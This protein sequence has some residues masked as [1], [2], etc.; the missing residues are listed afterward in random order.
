MEIKP[1]RAYRFDPAVVGNPGDCIVPPYDLSKPDVQEH[2]YRKNEYNVV[3]IIS[4]RISENDDEA[5]NQYTRAARHLKSWIEKGALKQDSEDSIYAYIQDFE[6]DGQKFHRSSFISLGRLEKYGEGVKAHEDT[7]DGVTA[8]F[9][10]LQRATEAKCGLIFMLYEDSKKIADKIIEKA[11]G[12]K[13]L[14]DCV[15]EDNVRHRLFKITDSKQIEIIS[16]MMKD[17]SCII[18]DGHHRYQT[19]LNYYNETGNPRAAWQLMAFANSLNEG[20]IV[21][22]THRLVVKL[23]NFDAKTLLAGL[24]ENFKITEYLFDSAETKRAAME[25]MLKQMK[26]ESDRDKNAY[27]IYLADGTFRTAVLKNKKAMDEA[28]AGKSKAWQKLEVSVLHKLILE[29]LLGIGEKELASKRHLEYIRDGGHSIEQI[30]ARVDSGQ[31]QAAFFVNP[32]KVKMIQEVANAGET[33]PQKST[34][35]YPKVFS[36][37]TI[38]KM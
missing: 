17:K 22:A 34:F 2:F 6:I 24:Q 21:L 32:E 25:K 36:G 15:D 29:K 35:F 18:A 16:R 27:G 20:V 19:A 3:R 14:I 23:K 28:A 38:Y 11:A 26:E 8:D 12:E 9:L 5:D 31:A 4:G 37:L 30:T 10:K 13:P 1:F 7:L 33:M